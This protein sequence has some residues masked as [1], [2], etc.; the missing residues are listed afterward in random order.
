MVKT[1]GTAHYTLH[2]R[3]QKPHTVHCTMHTPEW[4]LSTVLL[5]CT[6]FTNVLQTTRNPVGRVAAVLETGGFSCTPV[7]M[8]YSV[9]WWTTPVHVY[10]TVLSHYSKSVLY[11]V[12]C[13]VP[14]QEEG[15][16]TLKTFPGLY[17]LYNVIYV[18]K[19]LVHI[20]LISF[21]NHSP[22]PLFLQSGE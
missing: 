16:K 8:Y 15:F 2:N 9:Q 20:H 7:L 1:G 18:D 10:C 17:L 5:Q 19:V 13:R 11:C 3:Y 21:S 6:D 4:L 22:L 14:K 12:H